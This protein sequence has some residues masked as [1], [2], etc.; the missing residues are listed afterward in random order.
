MKII[1]SL[2]ESLS[3][4]FISISSF[5]NMF[6]VALPSPIRPNASIIL[7]TT[8]GFDSVF[9]ARHNRLTDLPSLRK[10]ICLTD[11]ALGASVLLN[12]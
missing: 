12:Y 7:L 2:F 8:L 6:N 4:F 3:D 10:P 11:S 1:L 9:N 5:S